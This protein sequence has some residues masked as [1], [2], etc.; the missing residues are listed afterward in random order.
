MVEIR[1][2]LGEDGKISVKTE[3]LVGDEESDIE[4]VR[5]LLEK[6]ADVTEIVH[7]PGKKPPVNYE[8]HKTKSSTKGKQKKQ[9]HQGRR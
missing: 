1:L 6:L 4:A 5:E 9:V 3:C 8:G 7:L 2:T